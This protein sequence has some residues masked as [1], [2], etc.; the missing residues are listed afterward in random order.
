M[1]AK[2]T[3]VEKLA[4]NEFTFYLYAGKELVRAFAFKK[5]VEPANCYNE[6]KNLAE[7]KR[8]AKLIEEHDSLEIEETIYETKTDNNE[9]D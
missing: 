9:K 1:K 8:M 2:I 3:R 7:A 4:T 6:E 5:D